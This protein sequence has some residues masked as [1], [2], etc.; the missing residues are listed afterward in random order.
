MAAHS[1]GSDEAIT[2]I[3]V[4]PLVDITLVLLIIFMVTA[5]Y[6]VKEGIEVDL[7]RAAHGGETVGPT[8]AFAIDRDGKLYLD[9][10][11]VG[12]DAARAA[13]R[14]ALARSAEARALIGA[15]RAVPHGEVVSVIDLVKSEGLTRFAIQIERDASGEGAP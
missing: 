2:G 11:P 3:N 7:P 4:T 9:G 14:A 10:Q 1:N 13:V 5:S 15:D 6:I 12:R 8:L